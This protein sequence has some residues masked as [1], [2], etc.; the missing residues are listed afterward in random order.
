MASKADIKPSDV[1]PAQYLEFD[2]TCDAAKYVDQMA[3]PHQVL[4]VFSKLYPGKHTLCPGCSEG[5]INLLT[6]FAAESLRNSPQGIATL[7]QGPRILSE[8][9]ERSIERMLAHGF[10]I[11]TLNSTGCIA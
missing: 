6:F 1:M 8:K 11:C 9:T 7:Y 5:V 3:L 2:R 4:F 10:H